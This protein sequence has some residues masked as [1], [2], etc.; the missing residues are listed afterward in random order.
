MLR[1]IDNPFIAIL[2]P[3]S[4]RLEM[5]EIR[6]A[7]T[8]HFFCKVIPSQCPF[9]RDVRWFG[10]TLFHIPPLCK[11]NPF[12]QQL[13]ELRFKALCYLADQCGEDISLYCQ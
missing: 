1:S 9:E 4:N 8:A 10:Q 13:I 11:L 7:E 6:N 2:Q 3:I 5:F 12:Y